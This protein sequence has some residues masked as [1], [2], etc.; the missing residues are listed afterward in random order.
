M[1]G[2]MKWILLLLA[3][4]VAINIFALGVVLGKQFRPDRDHR[5]GPREHVE[6]NLRRL[7]S[8]LPEDKK[9]ELRDI[10]REHRKGLRG[11]FAEMQQHETRIRELLMTETVD[12]AALAQALNDHE[13]MMGKLKGPV[14]AVILDVVSQL[15]QETRQRLAADLFNRRGP[16][17]DRRAPPPPGAGFRDDLPPPP[18]D[19]MEP[20]EGDNGGQ[21]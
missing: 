14:R 7:A 18:P 5:G 19:G 10:L 3:A 8:Y 11:R 17:G 12:L 9:G 4:S 15:D 13:A 21:N 1:T 2:K 6:F 20:D 16:R